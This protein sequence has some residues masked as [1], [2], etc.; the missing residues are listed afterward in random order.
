M[1][2]PIH[3]GL[4]GDIIGAYYEVYNHTPRTHPE[5]IFE[6]AMMEELRLRGRA[7]TRQDEYRIFYKERLVGVQRLDLLVAQEVAAEI[8]VVERL[9]RLHKAQCISYLKTVDKQVG[10]LLNFGGKKPEFH[11]LYFDPAKR[12]SA[13]P[14]KKAITPSPDWLYP[15]LAYQIVGGLYQVHTILGAGFV[16]RIYA[17]A[18]HHELKL[19][20]LAVEPGKRMQV[21]YKGVVIGDVAFGHIVVEGK[22]MVFPVAIGDISMI[23][24]DSLKD[25]MRLCDI[26]L[27]IL[28][29]FDAIRLEP[30]FIRA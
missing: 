9:T 22:I 11:R 7:T 5:S 2:K 24:L 26:Q 21:T 17:N 18:C 3:W 15:D 23:H 20:G 30:V 4:T 16:H 27:G 8:K 6:L 1:P 19:C 29:N 28:A 13:L 10:L 25:W 14:K 12:A